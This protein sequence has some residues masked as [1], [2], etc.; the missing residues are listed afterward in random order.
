MPEGY[1]FS[2]YVPSWIGNLTRLESLSI[3]GGKFSAPI[4]YQI[5]NLVNLLELE[6]MSCD[7]SGQQI[8]TWIGNLTKLTSLEIG[9][10]NFSGP[11]PSTIGN[12]TQLQSLQILYN[13]INGKIPKSLFALPALIFLGISEQLSGS[14]E[15]IAAPLSSPLWYIEL[16]DNQLTG[17][18]PKSFFQL[19]NLQY[20]NLESNNLTGTIELSSIWELK[21]LVL[22]SLS[23]NMITLIDKEGDKVFPSLPNINYI[24]L[25]SCHL[26]S[27][28][29]AFRYLD[30]ILELDLSNNQIKG[31][32]P[33]WLW[34]NW[35]DNLNSLDLSHNMLTSLEKS[36]SLVHMT[37]LSFLDLSSNQFQGSVPIPVTSSDSVALDY[38]NNNFSSI[39]PNFG[40][41]LT[42]AIYINLSKNK[43][44]GHIPLSFCSFNRLEIMDLSY[45]NF[46]GT[47]PSCLIEKGNLSMSVLKLRENKLHGVLP[48]NIREGC[49]LQTID[50]NGNRIEGTL[51]RSLANCQDLELLDVGNNQIVDSFPSWMGTLPNLRILVLRS[52]QLNGSIRDIYSGH[53]RTRQF[54]SLQIIDLASNHFSG[55]LHAE[56]FDN[57]K[58]MMNNSNDKGRTLEHYTNIRHRWTYED[59]V[60]ITYKESSFFFN[61]IQTTFRA[62]DFSNNLFDGPIPQSIGRLASLYGLNMSHNHFMGQIP[63]QL[64][65]LTRLESMDLSWNHLSGQ[66]PQDFT[67]LT[68]LAWLNV[69]YNN[70]T[71]RI[72]Q[73]NQFLSFPSSSFEG[74]ARLCGVQISKQCDAPGPDSTTSSTS[75]PPELPNTWCWWQDRLDAIILFSFVVLGYGVGFALAIKFRTFCRVA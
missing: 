52:N 22:L 72:P 46:S 44:S 9:G 17:S 7:V 58:S 43:L 5:G 69:S 55:D 12:L 71:G 30:T 38:S 59:T 49:K 54:T 61:K 18:I 15:D 50:L 25:E 2:Q 73:E 70:L 28:P 31:D 62:I 75:V 24:Y 3:W 40:R 65:D 47:I 20:L 37:Y 29:S 51:P 66:I 68:S 42:N 48:K 4:P 16:E 36:P 64:G 67:S 14:L 23:N 1:D 56:W 41:Y 27:L 13:N 8:P 34:E 6:F 74:N 63:S 19:P 26:Q 53:Q 32:I 11:I 57:L 35:K 45:N 10:C 39:I 60:T 21:S 33:S